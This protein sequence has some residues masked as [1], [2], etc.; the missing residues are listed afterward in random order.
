MV[1][2]DNMNKIAI[3]SD[4]HGNLEAL[5][6]ALSDMDKRGVDKVYCLGD[7]LA[8][9]TNQQQCFDLIKDRCSVIVRGNCDEYFAGDFDTSLLSDSEKARVVWNK[10]KINDETKEYIKNLPFSYEFYL[11]GRLVRLVHA[12]P[13]NIS[14]FVGNIDFITNY[15]PLFLPSEKTVSDKV[16]DVLI[17]GH[18]HTPYAQKIYNRYIINPGSVGDAIDVFRNDSKDGNVLFT[19][20]ANYVILTGNIDSVNALDPFS[21]EVISVSYDIDKELSTNGDNIELDAYKTELKEGKY[22]D[23]EKIYRSFEARG[24]NKEDI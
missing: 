13:E 17:C 21:Y 18:I 9:G 5:K 23:M 6:A 3:I 11:S 19:T 14:K 8:K 24:I 20:C 16:A 22:R 7:I 1:L 12:H 2:G 4:I 10:G 15:Y